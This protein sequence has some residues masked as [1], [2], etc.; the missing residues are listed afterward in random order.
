[1]ISL[2]QSLEDQ[3]DLVALCRPKTE[4]RNELFSPNDNYGFAHAMKRYSGYPVTESL[5]ATFPH[6][7]YLFDKLV[8]ESELYA[9]FG[10]HLNFPPQLMPA[11]KKATSNKKIMPFAAP[12]HYVLKQFKNEVPQGERRG[13]LFVPVHGTDK[14]E[15]KFDRE[16]VIEELRDLPEEFH[17]ITLCVHWSDVKRGQHLEF[18]KLGF[19][20]VCAGHTFDYLFVYRWLHLASQFK[21]LAGC[22]IGSSLFYS[23]L[24]GVPYYLTE[25]DIV[26]ENAP[27]FKPFNK[28]GKEYSPQ[29]LKKLQAIRKLFGEPLTEIS[30]A[31][32]DLVNLY[33]HKELV[34][35]PEALY[36]LFQSLKRYK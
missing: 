5:H 7:M 22:G 10:V 32:R 4:N 26:A 24:L 34:K 29:G 36:K 12:I 6:G 30:R 28:T 9:N 19:N 2:Q 8:L 14:V 25:E 33:T 18:Q 20:V 15:V 27:D 3:K 1:M 21:L 23:V 11:W 17:P 16:S 13:T 35:S 31:Q